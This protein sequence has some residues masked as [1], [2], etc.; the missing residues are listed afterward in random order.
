MLNVGLV[1]LGWWGT[2]L[3][4]AISRCQTGLR[5]V[6]CYSP[7]T[8]ERNI[9]AKRFDTIALNSF[10]DI[11]DDPS[12]DA[13]LLATP[14]SKHAEQV[15]AVVH[16]GK[17]V[18]VEKPFTL[19]VQSGRQAIDAALKSR[20]VLAVGHNRR[21]SSGARYLHSMVAD[22]SIGKVLHVEANYSADSAMRYSS[23]VWRADRREA[24][25]GALAS[26]GLHMIDTI[27]WLFG[28]IAKVSCLSRRV[29]V[30]VDI[31]DVT[32]ATLRLESGLTATLTTLF[33]APLTSHMRISGTECV[34]EMRD[35]FTRLTIFGV[36]GAIQ[37]VP[38]A[39]TDTVEDELRQ[40]SQACIAGKALPILSLIHI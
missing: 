20:R 23:G 28:P 15:I 6:A 16:S 22:H 7:I 5:L 29:A 37:D 18:F 11:L 21:L 26:L 3:A 30:P 13:V 17:H 2:E 19:T 38:L 9:F 4:Q 12:I 36:D 32:I 25:G 14:H 24:L 39:N 10:E 40:F 1:G 27:S 8:E 33:A 34:V 31:D 35:D